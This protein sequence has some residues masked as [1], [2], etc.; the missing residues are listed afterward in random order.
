MHLTLNMSNALH[1]IILSYYSYIIKGAKKVVASMVHPVAPWEVQF[2]GIVIEHKQYYD[3][4][5]TSCCGH[6]S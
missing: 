6:C 5:C 1:S 2:M 4:K 3:E